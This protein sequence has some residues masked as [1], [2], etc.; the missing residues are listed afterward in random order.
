MSMFWQLCQ[1]LH[2]LKVVLVVLDGLV[3]VERALE[4]EQVFNRFHFRLLVTLLS[5]IVRYSPKLFY[6][7]LLKLEL[8]S[9]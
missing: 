9:A 1:P 6:F 5:L 7:P 4:A 3:G 8:K 2:D